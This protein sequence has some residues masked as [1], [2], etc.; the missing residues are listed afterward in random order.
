MPL[1]SIS[2]ASEALGVH[3]RTLMAYERIGLVRPARRSNRRYYSADELRWLGCVQT[4]NHEG[5]IS[6]QGLSTLLRFVPCWAIR[7]ELRA[8]SEPAPATTSIETRLD[9]VR[10]A[11]AG[12]AP[13]YCQSCGVYRESRGPCRDALRA[14][15]TVPAETSS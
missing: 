3:P 6:L 11:Y 13:E 12:A 8:G 7:S 10:R 4:L 15:G 5:G 1:Q 9:R 2:A 14:A